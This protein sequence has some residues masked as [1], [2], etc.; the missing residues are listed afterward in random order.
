MEWVL[1][2][3][4]S[5]APPP[6]LDRWAEQL[7]ISLP[8]ARFL[9][10]R[11]V[12]T[13][14][15]MELFIAPLLGRLEPLDAWPGLFDA[16]EILVDGLMEGKT[17]CVWGDYDVD[18]IT[19]TA[20]VVEF[21]GLHGFT[22]RHYVPNR[23]TEGYGLHKEALTRLAEQ[24]VSFLLTVDSGI[25]DVDA[26]AHAKALGMTV[27]IS[28]HHLP[29]EIL[30]PA[31]AIVNP[32]LADCPCPSLAG[33]GVAFLLMAAV[34]GVLQTRGFPRQD[35]RSVL[36]LVALGTLADVVDLRGQNRIL[37]KNGLLKIAEGA[38]VGLA[39]LKS[40]CNFAPK[41]SLGSGQ[42][43]FTLAP[44][45]NAA[46]RLGSSDV[47]LELLL[48][49]DRERAQELAE[50]L[51]RLNTQRRSEEDSILD[52]AMA[53]AEAQ[54]AAGRMG[55]VLHAED[56]HPGVIG[57][58]ASRVV[59]VLHRPTVVLST[60]T[61]YLKGSGRS[62]GLFDIHEAF[63]ACAPLLLGYGGHFMAA[64][65]SLLPEQLEPF[66]TRFDALVVQQVGVE[67]KEPLCKL[68]GELAFTLAADFTF[69]KELE[70]LQPFGS[71]NAE[72]V[73]SSP[74]VRV[75]SMRP[76]T[77]LML[78]E[79]EDIASG[80]VLQAKA[81]RRLSTMPT[82]LKGQMIRVAFTPRIDRYNGAATVELRLKDWKLEK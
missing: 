38:R 26:I 60:V 80:V 15:D 65:L 69:L 18:G 64:G 76:R 77:N 5:V 56:W 39:A 59:E 81:W 70:M 82:S 17:L 75:K 2:S 61:E 55:L 68:D 19:S 74:P 27:I 20:V 54:V 14:P 43:V 8:L 42:V 33:V 66:R 67:A 48:T 49:R 10:T 52:E 36:D 50:A 3:D 21:L 7:E 53:Q 44:R 37:V 31:D 11:G 63:C 51:S 57:I 71:G 73:F 46:G 30:P 1:R 6:D 24:G 41:A 22:V 62:T 29:A 12:Q 35:V 45:I 32:R 9:W 28:D 40:S 79:L 13:L 47:A 16:A 23:L 58:V 25:S 4:A 78:L 72:P 34:N